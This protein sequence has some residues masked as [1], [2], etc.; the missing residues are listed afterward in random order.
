MPGLWRPDE[1][2][3]RLGAAVPDGPAYETIGGWLMAELGRVPA[4]GDEA[5]VDGWTVRVVDMDGHRVDRV[6]LVP[7]PHGSGGAEADD[8]RNDQW[9]RQ[10]HAETDAGAATREPE[11]SR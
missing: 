7:P 11:D 3:S 2:R 6:R 8:Q 5:V 1:V 4:V 9:G 10:R